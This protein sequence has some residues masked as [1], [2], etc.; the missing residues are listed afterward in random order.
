MTNIM[1]AKEVTTDAKASLR[2]LVAPALT[3]LLLAGCGTAAQAQTPTAALGYTLS[4]FTTGPA[5]ATNVDSLAVSG[6]DVFIGYA[7]QSTSDGTPTPPGVSDTSTIAEYTTGGKLEKSYTLDGGNDGL[8]VDPE[9]GLLWALQNQDGGAILDVIN[10]STGHVNSYTYAGN[11][12]PDYS[13]YDDIVFRGDTAFLSATNPA[14]PSD[15]VLYET[16]TRLPKPGGTVH[17]TPILHAGT[18]VDTDALAL[19][20]G[21]DLLLDDQGGTPLGAGPLP[22]LTLVID[23]GTRAQ[24]AAQIFP[25]DQAGNPLSL[26]D[27]RFALPGSHQLLIADTNA[28]VVYSLTGPFQPFGAYSATKGS[29]TVGRLDPATGVITPIVSGLNSPHGLAFVARRGGD[30]GGD[31]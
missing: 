28:N 1:C 13:G 27:T 3:G 30:G 9:T 22:S 14:S 26:D 6:T 10:P 23:P 4:T 11:L 24:I 12:H 25:K 17:L 20:P 21:G 7:D 29:H 19:T 5:A 2:R 15:V 18:L 16:S 31:R 8:R